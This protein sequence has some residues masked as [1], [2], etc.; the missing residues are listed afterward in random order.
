MKDL[1]YKGNPYSWVGKRQKEVIESCLDRAFINTDWQAIYPASE[2]EFLPIAGSDHAP[3]I[4]HIAEEVCVKRGQFR[5]D[6][7]HSRSE[8][9]IASVKRGWRL[10]R[11][12]AH[13]DIQHKLRCCRKEIAK[14]KRSTKRNSAEQIN[15]LKHR[16]DAAERDISTPL[17]TLNR[18][19]SELNRAY[20][21]EETF[22]KLKSINQWLKL[23]ER[24][25]KYFQ[26]ACKVRKSRNR[27]KSI[28]DDQGVEHFR[29]DAIGKVAENYFSELFTTSQ[30]SD[31]EAIISDIDPRE[32][33][34]HRELMVSQRLSTINF[35]MKLE[36]MFVQ[37]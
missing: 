13:G 3:V 23:G 30:H 25:T 28:I 22:W 7:R 15:I 37:W 12:D 11:T 6:K 29:D 20:R 14:W 5:Y 18:L 21:E 35:G 17:A 9:F 4:I 1:R 34:E 2:T 26:A 16:I 32:Q 10:G 36:T 27:I 8:D 33:I 24:N 31:M 19:R